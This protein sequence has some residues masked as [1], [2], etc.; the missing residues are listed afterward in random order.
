[1]KFIKVL[2]ASNHHDGI[3][4]EIDKITSLILNPKYIP[5]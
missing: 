4:I 5:V 2:I 3:K 1:M